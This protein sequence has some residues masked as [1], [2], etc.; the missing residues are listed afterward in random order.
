[1]SSVFLFAVDPAVKTSAPTPLL[2]VRQVSSKQE[3]R[4]AALVYNPKTAN[5][6]AQ[7]T[8]QTIISQGSQVLYREAEQPIP[9][10][11]SSPVTKIGQLAVAGVT[12]GRYTLT[13]VVTDQLADK[14][15]RTLARSVDFTVVK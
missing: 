1:M 7:V 14:K 8:S 5:G 3:L 15:T 13:I 6:Q 4:Y 10:S 11:G 12:P 9:Y 2:G